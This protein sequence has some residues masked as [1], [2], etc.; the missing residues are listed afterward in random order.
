[1]IGSIYASRLASIVYVAQMNTE[2]N[3]SRFPSNGFLAFPPGAAINMMN[4]T[5]AIEI[6][7]PINRFTDNGSF[8]NIKAS[9]TVTTGIK[10]WINAAVEAIV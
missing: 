10:L 1:M 5:P 3:I 8:R 6:P 9:I 2:A 7:I 4:K